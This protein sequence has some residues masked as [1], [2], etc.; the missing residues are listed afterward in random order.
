MSEKRHYSPE[1]IR[2]YRALAD[3]GGFDREIQ[4]IIPTSLKRDRLLLACGHQTEMSASL[5]RIF[6]DLAERAHAEPRA[7]RVRCSDCEEAWLRENG[8]EHEH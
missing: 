2:R 4:E 7:A 1:A 3:S 8:S 6:K 5:V